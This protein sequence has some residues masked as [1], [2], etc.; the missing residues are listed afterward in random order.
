MAEV[1]EIPLD[2]PSMRG[3][4]DLT[5]QYLNSWSQSNGLDIPDS[6]DIPL[7]TPEQAPSPTAPATPEKQPDPVPDPV[8]PPAD[9][10][11]PG[12][13]AAAARVQAKEQH[14]RREAELEA[15]I[16]AIEAERAAKIAELEALVTTHKSTAE[17]YAK[18]VD[19]YKNSWKNERDREW[20]EIAAE[21]P[22]YTETSRKADVAWTALFPR[23][24]ANPLAGEAEIRFNPANM[25]PET[26]QAVNGLVQ[27]WAQWEYDDK[28][29]DSQRSDVQHIIVS[30]IARK[31]GIP[32]THM[33]QKEVAGRVYDVID[34]AHPVYNHLI[35]RIPELVEARIKAAQ[36][37]QRAQQESRNFATE[38]IRQ[39]QENSRGLF[40][41]AGFGVRGDELK[42]RLQREPD[43]VILQAMRLIGEDED[44]RAELEAHKEREAVTNGYWKPQMTL[45]EDDPIAYDRAARTHLATI[46][47]RSIHAA[48]TP[49]L[50][51]KASR[52][53]ARIAELEARNA[54]LE[55][56]NH[57]NAV[58]DEPGAAATAGITGD[59]GVKGDMDPYLANWLNGG[60]LAR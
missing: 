22:E 7:P 39:R 48:I 26:T 8:T 53:E 54:K 30:S 4:A 16:A 44:L 36:L 14:K 43:N 46:A 40:K 5:A 51:K 58:Q 11:K 57:R 42:T 20:Q 41:N 2:A 45:T 1:A 56:E 19:H 12:A 23:N 47:A 38:A 24:I 59:K 50:V 34:P 55:E 18:D 37:Q 6:D 9:A 27:K 29:S 15:R 52:M 31:L 60:A 10:S 49:A 17:S 3:D 21:V 13:A 25:T 32:D 35:S 28:V 33:Q